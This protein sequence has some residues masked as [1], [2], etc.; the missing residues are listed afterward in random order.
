MF[1]PVKLSSSE[2]DNRI[3]YMEEHLERLNEYKQHEFG[4]SQSVVP[5]DLRNKIQSNHLKVVGYMTELGYKDDGFKPLVHPTKKQYEEFCIKLRHYKDEYISELS[6]RRPEQASKPE[7][8]TVS[9]GTEN[10]LQ[11][12]NN[13]L[14]NKII[15]H[16]KTS[17]T[18]VS[19]LGDIRITGDMLGQGGNAVVF[20]VEFDNKAA[21]KIL[22]EDTKLRST[23]FLRFVNEYKRLA[24]LPAHMGIISLYHFD[25]MS[26]DDTVVPFFVMEQCEGNL[27]AYIKG[28]IP[29]AKELYD[30]TNQLCSALSHLH[31]NGIV[32]RDIKPENVL[33]RSD[34]SFVIS[35]FGIAW[36]DPSVYEDMKLTEKSDRMANFAFS[37][38]EQFDSTT[39]PLPASD[40]FALGQVLYWLITGDTV[41]GTMYIL[42]SKVDQQYKPFDA[43]ITKMLCQNPD[44]RF[45]SCQDVMLELSGQK[46]Q[47][48]ELK[49]ELRV[50][51]SINTF[52]EKIRRAIPGK[53]GI[54]HFTDS[55]TID[56]LLET[57]ADDCSSYGLHWTHGNPGTAVDRMHKLVNDTWLVDS[58]EMNITD[59]WV[60]HKAGAT[61][62][63]FLLLR[64][65]GM[66]E[67]GVDERTNVVDKALDAAG[68]FQDRYVPFDEYLDGYV[69]LDGES[70]SVDATNDQR[71]RWLQPSYMFLATCFNPIMLGKRHQS[72][73]EDIIYDLTNEI[74]NA[75]F[76]D[77]DKLEVLF[78]LPRHSVSDKYA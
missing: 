78:K 32:H 19:D 6:K 67:F 57:I 33:F 58:Y 27:K 40:I 63:C 1:D 18:I 14:R 73:A 17:G 22:V 29:S 21:V 71:F 74:K 7:A 34:R 76:V 55:P 23:R 20:P 77:V 47:S 11:P 62:H 4:S 37:A 50:T 24:K 16:V 43:V 45:K 38:P 72:N 9:V 30:I 2:I 8:T 41:Q 25:L 48:E 31:S 70:V 61:D 75:D 51:N 39:D 26:V 12:N 49:N 5:K 59:V 54:L 46:K 69:I 44:D 28:G 10:A 36:F 15:K 60:G 3:R 68:Y 53:Y 64:S 35:D 42:P 66:P 52:E 13:D 65:D 56:R